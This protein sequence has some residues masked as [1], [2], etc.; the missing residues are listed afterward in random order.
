ML[1]DLILAFRADAQ[2]GEANRFDVLISVTETLPRLANTTRLM[3]AMNVAMRPVNASDVT[4]DLLLVIYSMELAESANLNGVLVRTSVME[5][6][7]LVMPTDPTT[8]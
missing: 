2:T 1:V 5:D 6:L 3:D 4:M 7:A 8:G